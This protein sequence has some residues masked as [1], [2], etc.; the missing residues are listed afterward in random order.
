MSYAFKEF[1]TNAILNVGSQELLAEFNKPQTLKYYTFI[2]TKDEAVSLVIDQ[3]PV[4]LKANQ[5]LSLTPNQLL[6][7]SPQQDFLVFQFNREFYCIK[8]HDQEVS[9]LGLL[10][11]G[12]THLP[13]VQLDSTEQKKYQQLYAVFVDEIT[14]KDRIQ[15]EMLR[16][17][18]A[19]FIIKTTRLF[20]EQ[21]PIRKASTAQS[22]LLRQYNFLVEQYYK[23]EHKVS[24]YANQ[25]HKSPKT[26]SNTFSKYKIAPLQV[27]HNRIVLEAQRL[28]MYTD[29]SSK[30]IAFDLGFEDA[31]HL[32]RLFKKINGQSPSQF[33]TSHYKAI[34]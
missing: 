12:N 10:F 11:F 9:C 18:M 30:E 29:K 1:S 20:K 22:D 34:S 24:F 19:R 13:V 21:T 31:S 3:V 28:L 15:A 26:L 25:L 23:R 7:V 33:R 2:W 14:T 17:L 5:I 8:D 6:E 16:M 32:S 4:Q 27:I